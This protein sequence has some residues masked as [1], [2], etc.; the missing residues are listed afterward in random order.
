MAEIK[1]NPDGSVAIVSEI[2]GLELLRVGGMKNPVQGTNGS[3]TAASATAIPNYRGQARM[4][5]SLFNA[6]ANVTAANLLWVNNLD[7][8]IIVEKTTLVVTT[9]QDVTFSISVGTGTLSSNIEAKG[10]FNNLIDSFNY[11]TAN[12]ANNASAIANNIDD[13]GTNGK[14]RQYLKVGDVLGAQANRAI[15]TAVLAL[16]VEYTKV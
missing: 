5:F 6:T 11:N 3:S 13:H 15:S 9:G 14:S 4:K 16:Y 2:E 1:Q 12:A 7:G 10:A 8:D